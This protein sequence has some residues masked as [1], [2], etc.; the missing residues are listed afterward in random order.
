MDT[1]KAL[2]GGGLEKFQIFN[3]NGTFILKPG[4]SEYWVFLVG[5]GSGAT[6]AGG[7]GGTAKFEFFENVTSNIT[8]T[9]GAG[10]AENGGSGDA[11]S[12]SG[13]AT[14]SS[15]GGTMSAISFG[16]GCGGRAANVN[17][18]RG[19]F[20]GFA[21]GGGAKGASSSSE[22]SNGVDGGGAYSF[23]GVPNTGG[24]G[25]GYWSDTGT[26]GGSGICIIY[27]KD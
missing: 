18:S 14:M 27:W 1:G 15:A 5:G 17:G 4:V 19:R 16:G 3:S 13:G 2:G 7:N 11:S 25:G 6:T 9:I 8:V 10:G 12:L 24:G 26:V 21:G 20:P 22:S 23:N